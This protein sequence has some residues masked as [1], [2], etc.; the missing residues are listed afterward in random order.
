MATTSRTWPGRRPATGRNLTHRVVSAAGRAALAGLAVD[1]RWQGA[2]NVPDGPVIL[3][4]NHV[5][6]VDFLFIQ[7]ALLGRCRWVR[8]LSRHDVWDAPGVGRLMDL[9]GHVPVDRAA[10]AAAYLR[11]RSLLEQGEAVGVFPEAGISYSLTVRPLMR[12]VAALARE[13]GVPVVPVGIF[14]SQRIYGVWPLDADGNE[15]GLDR[16][17]GRRVDVVFGEPMHVASATDL[18]EWTRGLGHTLTDVLEDLQAL[19]HH[20]PRPGEWAPWYPA[21]LG[22][23]ALTRAEAHEWDLV[24]RAAVQPT[25]GPLG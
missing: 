15:L 19:P 22:G 6:Y 17:R 25:W 21:H 13:T 10:P 9:M 18:T 16:S 4:A 1:V 2:E 23:H 8:F 24:P 14:G 7:R 5:S 20:R 11:A 12:G 3:A